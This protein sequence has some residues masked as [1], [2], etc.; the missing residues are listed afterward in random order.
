MALLGLSCSPTWSSFLF[1]SSFQAFEKLWRECRRSTSTSAEGSSGRPLLASSSCGILQ[2]IPPPPPFGTPYYVL[3]PH[4]KPRD[5]LG[6]LLE[7]S[8][9]RA[10]FYKQQR[11]VEIQRQREE[12]LRLQ[13]LAKEEE[14]QKRAPS[15]SSPASPSFDT[16]TASSSSS[17]GGRAERREADSS[18]TSLFYPSTSSSAC[19]DSSLYSSSTNHSK[20]QSAALRQ[21]CGGDFGTDQEGKREGARREEGE[22]C[23]DGRSSM[24]TVVFD[25]GGGDRRG[26]PE[27]HDAVTGWSSAHSFTSGSSSSSCSYSSSGH[28]SKWRVEAGDYD[29]WSGSVR[30]NAVQKD[31][32]GLG[33]TSSPDVPHSSSFPPDPP[34]AAPLGGSSPGSKKTRQSSCTPS[35]G[36]QERERG[37]GGFAWSERI[38]SCNREVFG[39]RSFRPNQVSSSLALGAVIF[40]PVRSTY[41]MERDTERGRQTGGRVHVGL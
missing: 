7:K 40:Y 26:M 32:R 21:P 19:S 29:A 10:S 18:H 38:E 16:S 37:G 34:P 35:K 24:R 33:Q 41:T 6:E 4:A 23:A 11:M 36:E 39:N 28:K 14:E 15:Q 25:P 31:W 1:S 8:R 22:G 30:V 13:Q 27:R 12:A 17:G 5:V 2:G 20:P 3:H 9:E